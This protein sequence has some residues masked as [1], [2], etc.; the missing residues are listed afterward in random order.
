VF[1]LYGRWL[2]TALLYVATTQPKVSSTIEDGGVEIEGECS[3]GLRPGQYWY[4]RAFYVDV[5][6]AGVSS[7]ITC[8]AHN[9]SGHTV[10][11][12]ELLDC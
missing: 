4:K 6:L 3:C 1:G 2:V 5:V 8:S 12:Y 7:E 9:R 11:Q 10:L